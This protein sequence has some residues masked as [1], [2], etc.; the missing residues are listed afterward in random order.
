[1]RLLL[2][3]DAYPPLIGG[4]D[5][6][7]QMLAHA[8]R[9]AGHEVVVA[10][11]WQP[12]LPQRE[13]DEGVDVRRLRALATVLPMFSRDP[14]RRHHPPFPD[15]LTAIALRRLIRRHRPEL[16]HSYGWITYSVVAAL[17]ATSIP[18][19]VSARDYG[20]VCAVR[21]FLHYQGEVCSGPSPLK[22]LRCAAATYTAD[23]AGN[24]VLGGTDARIT[25]GNRF[26]GAGKA[27][28]A[29]GG[30][31]LGRPS[32]RRRLAGLHSVST[33]VRSVMDRD[34]LGGSAERLVERV[35]PSF[36]PPRDL[37]EFAD[38][39]VRDAPDPA[40]LAR[41]PAEPYLLFVG[42]LLPQKGIWPLLA[43]YRRLR[44]PAPPLVLIGPSSYKSPTTFPP[45]VV[46]LGPATHATVLAAWDRAILGI[47]PSVGAETF[48]NVVT[49]AMSRGRPVVASRLGGIVDII[50]DGVSGV[51]VRP[52]DPDAL[53]AAI[54]RLIDDDVLR[55]RLGVAARDRVELFAASRVLPQFEQLYSDVLAASAAQVTA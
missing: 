35:I 21:N 49:E 22:C 14:G 9:D 54:Q 15:P 25:A 24:G 13:D 38:L 48:G 10:T 47:V 11:P 8:M 7:I 27:V 45:G 3:T 46:A 44:D 29:V 40:F 53:A 16:V 32:L 37:R 50:E 12:S 31:Y 1:M 52:A 26:R 30:T 2:V 18:L 51:L 41:L 28:V 34:L 36:L 39:P 23:D 55:E 5:R 6:Q 4:A 33:F 20:Y 17:V 19:V 43:A 42:A